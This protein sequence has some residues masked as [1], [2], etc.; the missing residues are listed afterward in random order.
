MV[1]CPCNEVGQVLHMCVVLKVESCNTRH[2][3]DRHH[4]GEDDCGLVDGTVLET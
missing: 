4:T 3:K 2:H 1:P